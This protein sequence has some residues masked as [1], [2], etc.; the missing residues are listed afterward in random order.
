MLPRSHAAILYLPLDVHYARTSHPSDSQ[1]AVL[2]W[3][4]STLMA[5]YDL[6]SLACHRIMLALAVPA[7]RNQ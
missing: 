4:S 7:E 2:A 1:L 5:S 3:R 6:E